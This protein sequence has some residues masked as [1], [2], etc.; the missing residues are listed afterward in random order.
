MF[1]GLFRKLSKTLVSATRCILRKQKRQSDA[2]E[3][4]GRKARTAWQCCRQDYLPGDLL[5]TPHTQNTPPG[6]V[7]NTG[8]EQKNTPNLRTH[9]QRVRQIKS[10]SL[11]EYLDLKK[12][13]NVHTCSEK[14]CYCCP[15]IFLRDLTQ[16]GGG[17]TRARHGMRGQLMSIRHRE[18]LLSR[19][20]KADLNQSL[21]RAKQ[22]TH[23][24]R[25]VAWLGMDCLLEGWRGGCGARH[26]GQTPKQR[27]C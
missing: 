12:F 15:V 3:L 23:R 25:G 14:R 22:E 2:W 19:Q 18:R 24:E 27:R 17:T 4:K 9:E 1:L 5:S 26:G 8:Y 6:D 20:K 16:H 13:Q 11:D 21:L 7:K 10:S